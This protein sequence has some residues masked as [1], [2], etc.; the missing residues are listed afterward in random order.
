[1]RPREKVGT[2]E[3]DGLR[4]EFGLVFYGN[5]PDTEAQPDL[6]ALYIGS[7]QVHPVPRA[8]ERE[9]INEFAD[10]VEEWN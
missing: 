8:L 5:D 1:M 10:K 4:I 7:V 6:R 2:Y 9:L 3:S